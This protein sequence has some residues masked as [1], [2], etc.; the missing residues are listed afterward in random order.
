MS[1]DAERVLR[2]VSLAAPS[3]AGLIARQMGIQIFMIK[4]RGAEQGQL[5][6]IRSNGLI[7]LGDPRRAVRNPF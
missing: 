7:A 2:R 4:A 3:A 1:V 5:R 6:R